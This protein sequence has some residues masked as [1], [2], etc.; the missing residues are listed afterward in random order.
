MKTLVVPNSNALVN[1]F[2]YINCPDD[3]VELTAQLI[4][5]PL[6]IMSIIKGEQ[7]FAEGKTLTFEE[8]LEHLEWDRTNAATS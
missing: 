5:N 2:K 1:Y 4:E 6:F 7:D 8:L 3:K